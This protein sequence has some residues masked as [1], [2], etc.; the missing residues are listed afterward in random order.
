MTSIAEYLGIGTKIDMRKMGF[1]KTKTETS[2]D[3]KAR[4]MAARERYRA[5]RGTLESERLT[6]QW[7]EQFTGDTFMASDIGNVNGI[8]NRR[9]G[10]LLSQM[11]LEVVGRSNNGCQIYRK[12]QH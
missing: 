10:Y 8:D 6:T 5:A 2:D 4:R 11:E 7:V 12:L 3:F 1:N 9:V